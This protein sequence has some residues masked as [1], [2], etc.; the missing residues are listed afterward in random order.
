MNLNLVKTKLLTILGYKKCYFCETL[1]R[2][3]A[4]IPVDAEPEHDGDVWYMTIIYDTVRLCKQH[5]E[6]FQNNELYNS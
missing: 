2:Q 5:L 1:S 3:E 6:A 4:K